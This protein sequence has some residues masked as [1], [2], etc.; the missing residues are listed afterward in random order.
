MFIKPPQK[1]KTGWTLV[2]LMV[3][4]GIFSIS[5]IAL[6]TIFLFCVRAFAANDRIESDARRR[7]GEQGLKGD[8]LDRAAAEAARSSRAQM[9]SDA[10][11][12]AFAHDPSFRKA[13]GFAAR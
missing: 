1:L 8:A 13:A 12:A 10:A 11:F 6:A 7:F 5:G 9:E 2:E 4:T 3:A